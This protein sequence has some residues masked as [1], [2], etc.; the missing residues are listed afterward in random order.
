MLVNNLSKWANTVKARD[1]HICQHCG[2]EDRSKHMEA[3]H[4]ER[5]WERPDI[6]LET[7]NGITLCIQCHREFHAILNTIER[8]AGRSVLPFHP[9]KQA[10][11]Q[12]IVVENIAGWWK[13]RL[14]NLAALQ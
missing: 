14:P 4:I 5:V 1:G 7:D 13:E 3:H 12:P 11:R 6:A 10:A 2:K 9:P 8:P